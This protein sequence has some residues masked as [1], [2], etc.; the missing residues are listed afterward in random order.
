MQPRRILFAIIGSLGD[1]H[2]CLALGTELARRGHSVKV[3]THEFYRAKVTSS[4]LGFVPM[5]PAWNPTDQTL[6]AQCEEMRTGPE[7]LF[8]RLIL[9][10]LRD[11]YGDLA[12]A[13]TA[14]DLLIAGEL[15]YAAP[16]V[17]KFRHLIWVSAILSP[18]SFV[19]AYDP[20][21][22][23][24]LPWLFHLPRTRWATYLHRATLAMASAFT[25]HWWAPVRELRSELRLGPGSNPFLKEKFSPYL[26]L[27]LFSRCMAE[28]QPD[29]PK[30]VMQPGFVSYGEEAQESDALG[31][32]QSFLASGEAPVVFTLGSTAVHHPG[33]FYEESVAA[34]DR[35][36]VRAVLLGAP[37]A[38]AHR[39][40]RLFAIPYAP[41]AEIFPRASVIVHQGGSGTTGAA[42]T[43]GKPQLVVPF[44]WDQ[45]DNAA[46][47]QRMGAG[48]WLA[49][50]KYTRETASAALNRLLQ[51]QR[52]LDR[53]VAVA[54]CIRADSAVSGACD[55]VE[56]LFRSSYLC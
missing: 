44:G 54:A 12:E 11:T 40:H 34:A 53:A 33:D 26:T 15:V 39:S 5:R 20:S 45:P 47:V 25:L 38:F 14:A 43:S 52:F 22:L 7:V 55:A 18:S 28:P 30:N 9:P 32:L 6:I 49:R 31:S 8:R 4:G 27:A 37:T 24:N 23:V 36:D 3:A 35:L 17:A 41:Y 10:H 46:R 51:E 50:A 2:P 13:A 42:L 1:L 21:L 48:L 29:W 19:S 16:I 56:A